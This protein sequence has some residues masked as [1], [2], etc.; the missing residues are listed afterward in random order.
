MVLGVLE[1]RR[2]H[3]VLDVQAV[4]DCRRHLGAQEVLAL[5]EDTGCTEEQLLPRRLLVVVQG[6]RVHQAPQVVPAFHAFPV[7]H[8]VLANQANSIPDKFPEWSAS[9]VECGS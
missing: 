4:Q 1:I 7:V 8:Q 6:I 9:V 3:C 5:R 2:F